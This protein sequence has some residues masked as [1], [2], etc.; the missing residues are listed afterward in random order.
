MSNFWKL[1]IF[2]L[3]C[4]NLII[5]FASALQ[6]NIEDDSDST[7]FV[8]HSYQMASEDS[9]CMI[10]I[11]YPELLSLKDKF[12]QDTLNR[13]LKN[14]FIHEDEI[15]ISDCDPDIGSTLE[16]NCYVEFNSSDLISIVQYF[17]TFNGGAHGYYGHDGYNLDLNSGKLLVLTDIIDSKM[18]DELTSISEKKMIEEFEVERFTDIG[19]FEEKLKISAEQDFYL[20]NNA[21]VI[22][23]DP[24]E[25]GPYVMGD[26][27]IL[28]PWNEIENLMVSDFKLKKLE[29]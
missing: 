6:A 24:Y 12:M 1:K 28:L 8:L 19:V 18:L 21:L 20:T 13:F 27:E 15:D 5:I 10:E 14:E 23:F 7:K 11:N 4:I 25:I 17:Y 9:M 26:V 3:Q 2:F 16:I 22:E 29:Q